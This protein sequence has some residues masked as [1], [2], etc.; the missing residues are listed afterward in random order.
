MIDEI[1][2]SVEKH[3]G[4]LHGFE[5]IVCTDPKDKQFQEGFVAGKQYMKEEIIKIIKR[6]EQ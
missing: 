3:A 4:K 6:Y 1:I 5:I 2:E